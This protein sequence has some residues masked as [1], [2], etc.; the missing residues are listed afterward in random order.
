M[1]VKEALDYEAAA[2][3]DAELDT[4]SPAYGHGH[5]GFRVFGNATFEREAAEASSSPR[6]GTPGHIK[7]GPV[8][9]PRMLPPLG[10]WAALTHGT[11]L[12]R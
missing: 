8:G 10:A 3:G 6:A 12:R 11:P 7:V 2:L 5:S 1:P 4:R 9:S